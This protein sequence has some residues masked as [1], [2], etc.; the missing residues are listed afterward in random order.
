MG[1][2]DPGTGFLSGREMRNVDGKKRV[3]Y[4][5]CTGGGIYRISDWISVVSVLLPDRP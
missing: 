2:E 3:S 5:I 4:E 1:R